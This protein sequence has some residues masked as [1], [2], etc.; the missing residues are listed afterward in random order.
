MSTHDVCRAKKQKLDPN[1]VHGRRTLTEVAVRLPMEVA[2][3][4][5]RVGGEEIGKHLVESDCPSMGAA[6]FQEFAHGRPDLQF[7]SNGISQ[8][9]GGVVGDPI[10][11]NAAL[12]RRKEIGLIRPK[13]E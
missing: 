5:V 4:V 9:N 11:D 3:K 8:S 6:H 10:G 7:G 1:V 13:L 12:R 2:P